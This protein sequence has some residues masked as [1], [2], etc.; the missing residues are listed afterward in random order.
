MFGILAQSLRFGS[1]LDFEFPQVG[2]V[3]L[4]ASDIFMREPS[5]SLK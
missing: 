2:F 4:N 1:A 5:E 3:N